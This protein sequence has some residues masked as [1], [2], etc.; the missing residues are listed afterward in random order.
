MNDPTR[1]LSLLYHRTQY[2]PEQQVPYGK[3]LLDKTWEL[4]SFATTY[5]A[6]CI[7]MFGEKYG[8]PTPWERGA[9]H[10]WKIFGFPLGFLILEAQ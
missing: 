9:S 10:N 1:F 7:T 2:S 4:G 3:F 5:N 8:T 6:K